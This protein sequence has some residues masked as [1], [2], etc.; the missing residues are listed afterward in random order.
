MH[1]TRPD[2]EVFYSDPSYYKRKPRLL[3]R[4]GVLSYCTPG[5]LRAKGLGRLIG[6]C[7]LLFLFL[8]VPTMALTV[9]PQQLNRQ[10]PIMYRNS[11]ASTIL[12]HDAAP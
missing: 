11:S 5:E 4:D 2:P 6:V 7:P 12:F 10:S 8:L 1:E 9:V 3:V